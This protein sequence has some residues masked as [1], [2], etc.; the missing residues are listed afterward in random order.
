LKSSELQLN[1]Q[2]ASIAKP[3][4]TGSEA[5][6]ERSFEEPWQAQIFALVLAAH[7]AGVFQWSDWSAALG[8]G[9]D[10]NYQGWI[11][12]LESLLAERDIVTKQQLEQLAIT[13]QEAAAATPH[14]QPILLENAQK[15]L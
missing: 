3:S 14:G 6:I 15:L 10:S 8:A 7:E 5:L 12:A 2:D 9:Q 1:A 4:E 13:W 11:A